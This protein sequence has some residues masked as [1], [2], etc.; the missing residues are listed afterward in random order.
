M[1][2][3]KE[4]DRA[5]EIAWM[6][7]KVL[8]NLFRFVIGGMLTILSLLLILFFI[9]DSQYTGQTSFP[10]QSLGS[11]LLH[12]LVLAALA[13]V[14]WPQRYGPATKLIEMYQRRRANK[15]N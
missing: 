11:T 15:S 14:I 13:C 4:A 12:V 10:W 1:T 5:P 8:F 2:A 7:V 6:I 3:T 9:M